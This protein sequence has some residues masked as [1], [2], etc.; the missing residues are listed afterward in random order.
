M[1]KTI[2]KLLTQIL[3]DYDILI[4]HDSNFISFWKGE[5]RYDFVWEDEY[6]IYTIYNANGKKSSHELTIDSPYTKTLQRT[7]NYIIFPYLKEK[8]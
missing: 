5:M 3:D 2:E 6:I 8:I 1:E 4:Q 7:M